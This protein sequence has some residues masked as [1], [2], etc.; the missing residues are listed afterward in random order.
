MLET[1]ET[2]NSASPHIV[3]K[4]LDSSHG[5]EGIL[6]GQALD[7][8]QRDIGGEKNEKGAQEPPEIL[9]T[10]HQSS[11]GEVAQVGIDRPANLVCLTFFGTQEK[12]DCRVGKEQE[13]RFVYSV[14]FGEGELPAG[15]DSNE[16]RQFQESDSE[17]IESHEVDMLVQ[18]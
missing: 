15:H 17:E 7:Q 10:A 16:C 18:S 14:Q 3:N 1:S 5:G 12:D 2:A 8:E 4:S 6:P 9:N 11:K 13:Q